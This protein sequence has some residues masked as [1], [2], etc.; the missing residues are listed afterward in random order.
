M[1]ASYVK[2]QDL[3]FNNY[4]EKVIL[5]GRKGPYAWNYMNPNSTAHYFICRKTGEHS[6]RYQ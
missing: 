6:F 1:T 3:N 4:R 5:A 2:L